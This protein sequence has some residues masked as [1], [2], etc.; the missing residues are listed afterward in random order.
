[1]VSGGHIQNVGMLLDSKVCTPECHRIKAQ[2]V[3]RQAASSQV[4]YL[5][6]SSHVHS[7]HEGHTIALLDSQASSSAP[8]HE[9]HGK[10]L[11]TPVISHNTDTGYS[12]VWDERRQGTKDWG[13][14]LQGFPG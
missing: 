1:M 13:I 3:P 11:M 5:S 9:G 6:Q 10:V 12:S 2:A 4:Q 8:W 14:R 7:L